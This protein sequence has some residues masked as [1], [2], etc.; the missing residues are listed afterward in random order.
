MNKYYELTDYS[1]H[2]IAVTASEIISNTTNGV[3]ISVVMMDI[4]KR[5]Y[6]ELRNK[7][8]SKALGKVD[9]K[10]VHK[11]HIKYERNIFWARSQALIDLSSYIRM[12]D[13]CRTY[14][15]RSYTQYLSISMR[16]GHNQRNIEMDPKK[17]TQIKRMTRRKMCI[18]IIFYNT[19][20]L[21]CTC[22][23]FKTSQCVNYIFVIILVK[24]VWFFCFL[25]FF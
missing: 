4:S 15:N 1:M 18:W 6:I 25:F 5:W 17:W 19:V 7:E 3:N 23:L 21:Y 11:Q 14:Q 16:G 2:Q 22:I 13:Y 12:P 8:L 24:Y 20:M 10:L 9:F